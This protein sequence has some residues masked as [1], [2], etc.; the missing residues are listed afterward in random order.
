MNYPCVS[1]SANPTVAV[2]LLYP[3]MEAIGDIH[4]TARSWF[5]AKIVNGAVPEIW[6]D[7]KGRMIRYFP[8][9][10]DGVDYWI[11]ERGLFDPPTAETRPL[12]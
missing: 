6:A 8:V 7:D 4:E 1:L 12:G 11:A 9:T 2:V 10:V 5:T 3:H